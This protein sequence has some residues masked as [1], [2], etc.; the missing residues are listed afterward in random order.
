M[1]SSGQRGQ[2][3]VEFSIA[4]ALFLIILMG[5]L[6][7]GMA[8]FKYNAVSQAAREIARAASVHPG[9][10]DGTNTE[11]SA[12][13]ATQKGL[14]PGLSVAA[15]FTCVDPVTQTP[16]S[17]CNYA[18]DSVQVKV[19]APYKPITPLLGLI[20]TWTMQGTSSAQIQ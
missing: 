15:P 1:R 11:V 17:P 13:I 3:L 5:V 9:T 16:V 10:L 7:F 12:V 19:T 6:D 4:V 2:A 14:V 18:V 20:G 8:I